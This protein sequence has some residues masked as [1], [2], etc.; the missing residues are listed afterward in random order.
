M[1]F[2]G[3]KFTW[4][5]EREGSASVLERLDRGICNNDWRNLFPNFVIRHL[6]FWGSDHRPLV[7][8]FSENQGQGGAEP[9]KMKRRFLFEE[10][11]VDDSECKLLVD[12][13]WNGVVVTSSVS[14]IL[15][16]IDRCG[17]VLQSWNIAKRRD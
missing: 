16:K 12:S 8:S 15:K 4:S 9:L 1:G 3:P 6:D 11:W 13:V 14:E 5:N 10:C 7:L 17:K 2:V